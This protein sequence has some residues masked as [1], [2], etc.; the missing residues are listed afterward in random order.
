MPPEKYNSRVDIHTF[1]KFLTHG[2]AYVKYGYVEKN[3]QVMVL[4]EF[5]VGKAYTFYTRSVSLDPERTDSK[6]AHVVKLFNGLRPS[7]RK[8]LLH[9][10]MNPEYTSWKE[11]V[12]E[13]EYQEMADN[14]DLQGFSGHGGQTQSNHS[15][16]YNSG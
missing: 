3:R 14:V 8:A 16:C 13:A 5:L 2:T 10:H 1:H 6:R 12:H 4:S 7:L 11:M 15:N 9:E